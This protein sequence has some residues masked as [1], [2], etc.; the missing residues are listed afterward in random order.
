MGMGRLWV[1]DY[2]HNTQLQLLSSE[3][4]KPNANR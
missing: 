4:T 1:P 3:N 2:M